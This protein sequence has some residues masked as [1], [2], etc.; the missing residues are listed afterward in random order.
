MTCDQTNHRLRVTHDSG[1][2][3]GILSGTDK[4][5]H[6]SRID[7][8]DA[9]LMENPEIVA[10]EFR[11]A[12]RRLTAAVSIIATREGATRYGIVAT[13]VSS[14]CM[15]PPAI[16]VCINRASSIFDPLVRRKYFSVSL[17]QERQAALVPVFGG[18]SK[19]CDRFEH[20]AWADIHDLP[21]LIDAQ[22]ALFCRLDGRL[23]YGS[24]E[25]VIGRVE[26]VEVAESISP[27][28]WQDGAPAASR[29]L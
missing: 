23:H 14:L 25:I 17:L 24:H 29:V 11:K 12:M 8:T 10:D 1:H 16:L 28:L 19:H 27:L 22:A 6:E 9:A 4:S 20:G 3:P 7:R 18:Q 26:A 13:A 15:A 5:P 2:P 21:F